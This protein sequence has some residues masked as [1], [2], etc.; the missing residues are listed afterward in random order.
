[1]MN[2]D[3]VR[4]RTLD[5]GDDCAAHDGHVQNAGSIPRQRTE[6]S[7]AQT[8][9]GWKHDGIE[10]PNGQDAPHGEMAMRE[11]RQTNQR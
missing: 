6:F 7:H 11:H 2:S 4:N 9:N 10:K 3:V 1:M 8:E 5:Q